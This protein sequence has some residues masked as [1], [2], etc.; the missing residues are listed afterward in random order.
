[1]TEP[2]TAVHATSTAQEEVRQVILDALREWAALPARTALADTIVAELTA[3]QLIDAGEREWGVRLADG[4]SPRPF[5]EQ[6]AALQFLVPAVGDELVYRRP[7]GGWITA[8]IP[9]AHPTV[10]EPSMIPLG[11]CP[12]CPNGMGMLTA[13]GWRCDMCGATGPAPSDQ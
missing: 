10:D 13:A 8:S 9:T 11:W 6:A 1:M 4:E 12:K 3:K 5:R 7:A 2:T